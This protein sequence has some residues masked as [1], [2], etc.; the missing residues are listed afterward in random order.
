MFIKSM[1]YEIKYDN[2][3]YDLL[4]EIQYSVW[5]IKNRATTLSYD[6]Q[7]Y[8][9]SY[10]ERFGLY[11]KSKEMLG[12]TL[13]ADVYGAVK[14]MGSFIHSSTVDA[15]VQEAVKNFQRDKGKI[16]KGE[17]SIQIYKRGGA[18]PV[19]AGQIKNLLRID[20][21]TYTAKL[22]L[23]SREGAKEYNR[24]TQI[25]VTLLTGKGAYEILDRVIEGSYKLCD[26][27]IVKAKKKYYLLVSYSFLVKVNENLNEDNIMGIDLG[28]TVPAM[29]ALNYDK[30]YQEHV[31]D[32]TEIQNFQLQMEARK[33]KLQRQ[34]KWCAVGSVGHGT[35]TR[36]KPLDKLSDKISSFKDTKNHCWS[37]YIVDQAVKLNCGTIQMENL[38]G[39]AEDNTFL[40]KWTYYD[41]QTKIEYKAK[42]KG[43]KVV[44]V[45]PRYTSSR[46]NKCGFI[47]LSE[48]KDDWRPMQD[49]FIC[50][51][52]SHGHDKFVNADI[53]AAKN[54]SIKGIDK[55][56]KKQVEIQFPKKEQSNKRPY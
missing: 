35:K 51:N 19:R 48:N 8:S 23:L 31:G 43:I 32:V 3:L 34:R 13:P 47:H 46:C 54:I 30:Y 45:D 56:I 6:W 39:I 36:I 29:L 28:V 53:N 16:L 11:P 22:S 24:N 52:C 12:K 4:R 55:I 7:Q 33:R 27:R 40:K 20:K 14:E 26:S 9:F 42:E 10:K 5:K 15:A 38:S 41:L 21:K 44:Y 2:E 25:D 17:Q 1:R 37:R 49:K 50:Q 18:F